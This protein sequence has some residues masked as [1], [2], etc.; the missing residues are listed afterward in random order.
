MYW[1]TE[2]EYI[3]K[4]EEFSKSNLISPLG[5]NYQ[6]NYSNNSAKTSRGRLF[7]QSKNFWY[8]FSK[9]DFGYDNQTLQKKS[10]EED[11]LRFYLPDHKTCMYFFGQI[12]EMNVIKDYLKQRLSQRDALLGRNA[13]GKQ[14]YLVSLLERYNSEKILRTGVP[15]AVSVVILYPGSKGQ[16]DVFYVVRSN[17]KRE[18]YKFLCEGEYTS[19]EAQNTLS[20][21][22]EQKVITVDEESEVKQITLPVEEISVNS[23]NCDVFVEKEHVESSK[24][25]ASVLKTHQVAI[26][27]RDLSKAVLCTESSL[28]SSGK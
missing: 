16:Q 2:K 24:N 22:N 8:V 4:E 3:K 23:L 18:A 26:Y 1:F 6:I 12:H 9:K 13:S 28:R 20:S 5:L 14:K 7:L 21:L 15:T 17:N 19:E 27:S 10:M 11:Y 25:W